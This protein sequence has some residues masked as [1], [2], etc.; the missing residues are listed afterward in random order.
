MQTLC[1]IRTNVMHLMKRE[2]GMRL[3]VIESFSCSALVLLV[4]SLEW[5]DLHTWSPNLCTSYVMAS[6]ASGMWVC[7]KSFIQLSH[8]YGKHL[9]RQSVGQVLTSGLTSDLQ[10]ITTHWY[11][12]SCWSKKDFRQLKFSILLCEESSEDDH[13]VIFSFLNDLDGGL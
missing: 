3:N 1:N 6:L 10:F 5:F 11:F 4:L 13:H 12:K 8:H 9:F 2:Y 7:I